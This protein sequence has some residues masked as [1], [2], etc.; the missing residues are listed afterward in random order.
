L[1]IAAQLKIIGWVGKDEIDALR[2]Q[3]L[4]GCNAIPFDDGIER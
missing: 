3:A 4:K 2:R 1:K